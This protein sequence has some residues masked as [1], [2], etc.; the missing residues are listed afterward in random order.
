MLS[1]LQSP[2]GLEKIFITLVLFWYSDAMT[3][4]VLYFSG[5]G[6]TTDFSSS[7]IYPARRLVLAIMYFF[8]LALVI[9]YRKRVITAWLSN[10]ILLLFVGWSFLSVLWSVSPD[11]SLRRSVGLLVATT[12][13]F[14]IATFDP[15]EMLRLL[16]W[17]LSIVML[18]SLM[19]VVTIPEL[20]IM[21]G[22][23][24]GAWRGTFSHKNTLGAYA[25]LSLLVLS[26]STLYRHR[27]TVWLLSAA[28][29][30]LSN[31]KTPIIAG[32]LLVALS[33][34]I[35]NLQQRSVFSA[36]KLA[37]L[38][39][40]LVVATGLS[41]VGIE[42]VLGLFGGDS[43]LT[44]RTKLWALVW[45]SI[46]SRFWLG[47]GFQTDLVEDLTRGGLPNA[48]NGLLE[49]WLGLGVVGAVLILASFFNTLFRALKDAH[50]I[51][52]DGVYWTLIFLGYIFLL[53]VTESS[54]IGTASLTW[55]LYVAAAALHT[56][57]RKRRPASGP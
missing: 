10:P 18:L 38:C 53:S 48:H 5:G 32:V 44:G 13:G 14:Y 37:L 25:L 11:V 33:T 3:V 35:R 23:H 6:L 22:T 12:F 42:T 15:R 34:F 16:A 51:G 4:P 56:D 9:P 54:L 24:D 39:M 1:P 47:H 30:F 20:G 55:V 57:V 46:Q 28:L 27:W 36:P 26:S 29:L 45:D 2:R 43:T 21:S 8:I 50:L 31:A 52:G 41:L 40:F 19:V 49:V 7:E 17:A